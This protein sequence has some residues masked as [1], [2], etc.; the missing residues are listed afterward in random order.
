MENQSDV[1]FVEE[2]RRRVGANPSDNRLQ[3]VADIIMVSRP[4]VKRWLE[5]KNLPM[6]GV[7]PGVLRALD[8]LDAIHG[9]ELG[10]SE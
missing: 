7:R 10:S 9:R 1:Q 3:E 8:A 2:L 4:T 5:G 6:Q